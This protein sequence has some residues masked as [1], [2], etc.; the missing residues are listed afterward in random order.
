MSISSPESGGTHVSTLARYALRS[1]MLPA[2][3]DIAHNAGHH[4]ETPPLWWRR[5]ITILFLPRRCWTEL[6]PPMLVRHHLGQIALAG[7]A[8]NQA[9]D[10]CQHDRTLHLIRSISRSHRFQDGFKGEGNGVA[11]NGKSLRG[12]LC[13]IAQIERTAIQT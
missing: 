8:I 5:R 4:S 12:R 3:C 6:N 9:D 13:K 2:D 7:P 11:G 1:P 10:G